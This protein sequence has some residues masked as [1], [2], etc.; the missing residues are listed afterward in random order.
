MLSVAMT[1][2]IIGIAVWAV[3]DAVRGIKL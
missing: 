2:A 1:F 3:V